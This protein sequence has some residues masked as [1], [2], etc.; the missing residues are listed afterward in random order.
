MQYMMYMMR[1]LVWS[2]SG[3]VMFQVWF[4]HLCVFFQFVCE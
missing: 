2:A 3:F 4:A 1:G